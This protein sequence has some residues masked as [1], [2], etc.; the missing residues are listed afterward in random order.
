MCDCCYCKECIVEMYAELGFDEM[1]Y[2]K[3]SAKEESFFS[4]LKD[5]IWGW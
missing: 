3:E 4:I 1:E 5:F 2:Q